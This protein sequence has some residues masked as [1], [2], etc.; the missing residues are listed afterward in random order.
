MGETATGS[1]PIEALLQKWGLFFVRIGSIFEGL[2]SL[3]AAKHYASERRRIRSNQV[4]KIENSTPL[5]A[6]SAANQ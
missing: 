4:T 6:A 2:A 3:A 1:P 5:V